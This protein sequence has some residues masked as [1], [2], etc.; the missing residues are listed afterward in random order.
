MLNQMKSSST[1]CMLG[2]AGVTVA[3]SKLVLIATALHDNL[4]KV[5]INSKC[6][7]LMHDFESAY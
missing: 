4:C 5:S 7:V 3:L 2:C 6:Y 1:V